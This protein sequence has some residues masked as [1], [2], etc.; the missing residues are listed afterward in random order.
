MNKNVFWSSSQE[1][2][3]QCAPHPATALG[4]THCGQLHPTSHTC[5]P[6]ALAVLQRIQHRTS[7][8][9]QIV[10]TLQ[11]CFQVPSRHAP[12]ELACLGP[13]RTAETK[14][15]PRQTESKQIIKGKVTHTKQQGIRNTHRTLSWGARFWWKGEHCTAGHSKTFLQS[16]L[17]N[18][19]RQKQIQWGRQ[20][21]WGDREI[22]PKWKNRTKPQPEIQAKQ[23]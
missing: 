9:A 2:S 8:S 1:H 19:R 18:S 3:S 10:L 23:I 5:V 7:G 4:H 6:G 16:L 20:T 17:I 22:Y 21:K 11:P 15:S 12:S 14:H 13:T